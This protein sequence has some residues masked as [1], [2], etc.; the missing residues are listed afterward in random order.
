MPPR[1]A[2]ASQ[3]GVTGRHGAARS[4]GSLAWAGLFNTELWID[5]SRGVAA[6]LLVQVLPFYDEGALRALQG[7]ESAVYQELLPR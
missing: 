2:S 3:G 1:A 5:P 4:A 6:T 7:F